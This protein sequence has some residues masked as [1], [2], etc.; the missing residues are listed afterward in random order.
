MKKLNLREEGMVAWLPRDSVR[1]MARAG[2]TRCVRGGVNLQPG[3]GEG[4]RNVFPRRGSFTDTKFARAVS[5]VTQGSNS[6]TRVTSVSI[7]M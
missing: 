6:P 5:E 7:K 2:R 4:I 1:R 3:S